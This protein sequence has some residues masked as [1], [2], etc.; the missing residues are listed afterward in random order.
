MNTKKLLIQF[1]AW[2]ALV[3]TG[4]TLTPT[5]SEHQV[6]DGTISHESAEEVVSV[7]IITSA[8]DAALD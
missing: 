7:S 4:L 3:I 5:Q 6:L 8:A 2:S 1:V